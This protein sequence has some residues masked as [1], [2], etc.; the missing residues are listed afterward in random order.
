M[1]TELTGRARS[2]PHISLG[3]RCVNLVRVNLVLVTTLA[4][5]AGVILMVAR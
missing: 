2:I 4:I 1:T 5:W 3:L